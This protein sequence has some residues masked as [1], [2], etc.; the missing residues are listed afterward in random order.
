MADERRGER[1][2]DRHGRDRRRARLVAGLVLISLLAAGCDAPGP[3][4]PDPGPGVIGDAPDGIIGGGASTSLETLVGEW[5]RFDVVEFEQD[6]VTTTV[7]WRFGPDGFCRRTITTFSAVEGFPR[8]TE[9]DCQYDI[10]PLEI[11]ITF[12]TGD[13]G[14]FALSFPGFDPDRMLLDGFEYRRVA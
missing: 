6:L 10:G 3:A 11:T 4:A 13:T 9:V 2:R 1:C 7:H 5:E 8:T 12:S 14:T